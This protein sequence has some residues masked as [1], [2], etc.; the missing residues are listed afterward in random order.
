MQT[1]KDMRANANEDFAKVFSV[2]R[3]QIERSLKNRPRNL[4]D[5][6]MKINHYTYAMITSLRQQERTSKEECESTA[7]AIVSLKE[8]ISPEIMEL[9]KEQRLGYLVEGSRFSKYTRGVR[10]KE[11]FWYARLSPNHKS[12]HY[13]EVDEK[14]V[15]T[16]EE[17]KTKLL[18]VD[19]KQILVGKE[20]PNF[21]EMRGGRKGGSNLGFSLTFDSGDQQTLDFVAPD[22]ATFNFWTDGIMALLSQPMV[23]K[24][25]DEDFETLLSMEIKLRLLDILDISKEPPPIPEDPENYEFN[26]DS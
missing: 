3:E 18:V 14:T 16:M 7:S 23:S 6:K 13:G 24:Q 12:L 2:V 22:E 8:K 21:K 26:F 10:S 1:W 4:D 20:C 5:F 19:I 9:I 15:P 11:K 17:L 25:K